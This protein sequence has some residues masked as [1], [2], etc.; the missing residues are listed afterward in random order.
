MPRYGFL[1]IVLLL[2]VSA[3]PA[4]AREAKPKLGPHAVPIMEQTDYLT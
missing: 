2:A 3:Q 1:L 4:S